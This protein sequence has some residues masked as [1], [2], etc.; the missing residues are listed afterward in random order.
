MVF[1]WLTNKKTKNR[2]RPREKVIV[3]NG[4]LVGDTLSPSL[5]VVHDSGKKTDIKCP[6]CGEISK[7]EAEALRHH[8]RKHRILGDRWKENSEDPT[9]ASLSFRRRAKREK[10]LSSEEEMRIGELCFTPDTLVLTDDTATY[11]SDVKPSQRIMKWLGH[12]T[13]KQLYLIYGFTTFLKAFKRYYEGTIIT[14]KPHHFLPID[15]TPDHPIL[16]R[17]RT[18]YSGRRLVWVPAKDIRKGDELYIP[19]AQLF[20]DNS[21]LPKVPTLQRRWGYDSNQLQWNENLARLFGYYIAEGHISKNK[22]E[23]HGQVV[24]SL[25]R[26]ETRFLEDLLYIIRTELKRKPWIADYKNMTCIQVHLVSKDLALYLRAHFG[27]GAKNKTIPTEFLSM[28]DNLLRALLMGLFTGDGW[29][30]KRLMTSSKKLA[31]MVMLILLKLGIIPHVV[32]H[33][34]IGVGI[35]GR[36]DTA[37]HICYAV[38]YTPLSKGTRR[39]QQ[40]H[41]WCYPIHGKDGQLIGLVTKVHWTKES[42]YNGYVYNFKMR[43]RD[44]YAVPPLIAHNCHLSDDLLRDEYGIADP[45]QG[46]AII[47]KMTMQEFVDHIRKI[48]ERRKKMLEIQEREVAGTA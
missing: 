38:G 16:V 9:F 3:E 13:N 42:A 45:S 44:N 31:L 11:I 40:D 33:R 22:K 24:F 43:G 19:L 48:R 41:R 25:G 15:M 6:Y 5:G 26:K 27:A 46:D 36:T 18:H 28:P 1:G 23:P 29:R 37:E 14:I 32:T 20:T 8:K 30:Y 4:N 21:L 7:T 2:F 35:Q 47:D 10:R 39:Y 17:K 12:A 34:R